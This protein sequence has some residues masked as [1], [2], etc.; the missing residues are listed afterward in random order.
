MVSCMIIGCLNKSEDVPQ[1]YCR[2]PA[3][4][5]N[6]EA[7][8]EFTK[9]RPRKWIAAISRIGLTEYIIRTE[10][11]CFPHFVSGT[12]ANLWNRLNISW[13]LTLNLHHN[14]QG[15]NVE[16]VGNGAERTKQ[17]RK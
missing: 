5:T 13:V 16:A 17:R 10:R 7:Y 3:V 8:E 14:K 1:H 9:E 12:A 4:I 11:V 15:K 6:Q 2:I